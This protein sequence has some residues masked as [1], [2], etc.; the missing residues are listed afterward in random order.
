[1]NCD[2]THRIPT[3]VL[4]DRIMYSK[5]RM[6]HR[7]N[8]HGNQSCFD[9]LDVSTHISRLVP[10]LISRLI[11]FRRSLPWPPS[12]VSAT[13]NRYRTHFV[14]GH[15]TQRMIIINVHDMAYVLT[16]FRNHVSTRT[17]HRRLSD[18][19]V[20]IDSQRYHRTGAAN[21][22]LRSTVPLSVIVECPN[23]TLFGV[24]RNPCV[25][26]RR[27]G[28]GTDSRVPRR[29]DH[30]PGSVIYQ[31]RK[32]TRIRTRLVSVLTRLWQLN[33]A[34]RLE[35]AQRIYG[36]CQYSVW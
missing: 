7:S 33:S 8:K 15:I 23:Q 1:M 25:D 26:R 2:G 34:Q 5:G 22:T 17:T 6:G 29:R 21:L 20:T 9:V 13:R 14:D 36:I 24:D 28:R 27:L 30:L 18:R 35:I 32:M 31:Q 16:T 4:C 12:L 19:A 10:R 11:R 3:S